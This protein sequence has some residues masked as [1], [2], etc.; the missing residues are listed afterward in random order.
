MSTNHM[1]RVLPFHMFYMILL[2]ESQRILL[3]A[4][5]YE[6]VAMVWDRAKEAWH[7]FLTDDKGVN[8][9]HHMYLTT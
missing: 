1:S 3:E 9:I 6:K 8:S 2:F 4:P 5:L 7:Q